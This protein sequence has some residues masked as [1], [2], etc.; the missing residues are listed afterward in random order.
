MTNINA[1]VSKRQHTISLEYSARRWP[2]HDTLTGVMSESKDW[3]INFVR[4]G[5]KTTKRPTPA[6][7]HA[8]LHASSVGGRDSVAIAQYIERAP[9]RSL[10]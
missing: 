4:Y 3:A 8:Y 10:K 6:G 7:G 5:L 2:Q 1:L 9:P